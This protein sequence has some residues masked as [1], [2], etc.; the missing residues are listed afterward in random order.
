IGYGVKAG[1]APMHTWLPDAHSKAPAPISALLS[2]VLLNVA[3]FTILKFKMITDVSVG[4]EFTSAI[5]VVFGLLSVG[6][7]AMIIFVQRSYKR[8]LAYSS[9][10]NMGIMALGFG[11]GGIGAFAA[12]LHMLY[13]SIIKSALF[14]LSGNMLLAYSSSKIKNVKGAMSVIPQTSVL[15]LVGIFAVAGVPPFGIF[16]TKLLMLSSGIESYLVVSAVALLLFAIVFMGLFKHTSAMLFGKKP[17]DVKKEKE[18]AWLVFPPLALLAC[19]LYLS[20]H[21]PDI[22]RVLIERAAI[23]Y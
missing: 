8:L 7:A 19:A 1:F 12:V 22:L 15:F 13:H 2:G 17:E 23:L 6:I 4:E 9:I 11:F 20:I 16:L 5:F 3:F 18:S 21:T 14:L 10:E